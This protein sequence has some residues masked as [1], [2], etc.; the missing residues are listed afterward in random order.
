MT[1]LIIY[2]I[3][4]KNILGSTNIHRNGILYVRITLIL[5]LSHI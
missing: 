4:R 2:K 3:V 1:N 5:I